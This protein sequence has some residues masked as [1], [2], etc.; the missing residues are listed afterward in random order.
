MGQWIRQ[1][2]WLALT[3]LILVLMAIYLLAGGAWLLALG[4]SPYYVIAGAVLLSVAILLA[5]SRREALW[6]Y[7][8]LLLGTLVWA[9]WEAGLDFWWLAPRGDVLVPLGVWL[10]LPFISRHLSP[11]GRVAPICLGILIVFALVVMVASLALPDRFAIDGTLPASASD[12][13]A[14]NDTEEAGANWTAWGGT[15]LWDGPVSLSSA[16]PVDMADRRR[17]GR[18]DVVIVLSE[19]EQ[20]TLSTTS[21][22]SATAATRAPNL[23][24]CP[25]T[26]Y[27]RRAGPSSSAWRTTRSSL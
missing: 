6:L 4:G 8:A 24:R 5:M 7:G 15:N 20:K 14:P 27:G 16:R 3:I 9:L 10:L 21:A 25:C 1:R 13:A 17:S 26:D 23:P 19:I 18:R 11:P 12:Q 2:P 22:I